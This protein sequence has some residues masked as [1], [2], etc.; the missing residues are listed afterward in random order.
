MT[1]TRPKGYTWKQ[2]MLK[3]KDR[4]VLALASGLKQH[5]LIEMHSSSLAAHSGFQKRYA[6]ARRSFFWAG[7]KKDIFTFVVECDIYQRHKGETV[8]CLG[9][10]QSLP[11]MATIWTN[12][13]MDFIIGLL[14]SGNKSVIMVVVDKL[15]KYAHLCALLHP[16]TPAIV[17]QIFI[18]HIFKLHSMPTSIVSD[19]DPTFTRKFWQ[20]LFKLQG[21]Q[22]SMSTSYHLQTDGQTKFINK[23]VETYL[24]CF[25]SKKQHQWAQWLPLA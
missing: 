12:L 20:E 23:C 6:H 16:F 19:N 3:Y 13:S 14:K 10:L 5:I 22:L 8:K 4:L 15:S 18:D 7:M 9:A 2:G 21:T 1:L 25:T 11:I 17:A 24:H